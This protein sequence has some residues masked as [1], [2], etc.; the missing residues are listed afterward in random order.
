MTLLFDI[1]FNIICIFSILIL[2][3]I[4]YMNWKMVKEKCSANLL[5]EFKIIINKINVYKDT[6]KNDEDILFS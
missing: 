5:D 1:Y 6:L 2:F 4:Y 3:D